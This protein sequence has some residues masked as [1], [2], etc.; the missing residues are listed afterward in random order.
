M[1]AAVDDFFER[2]ARLQGATLEYRRFPCQGWP[3][4]FRATLHSAK[5]ESLRSV[6]FGDTA[7][8]AAL[9]AIGSPLRDERVTAQESVIEIYHRIEPWGA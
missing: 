3:K 9:D 7:V 1:S 4:C 8:E 2:G 6:G 5:H